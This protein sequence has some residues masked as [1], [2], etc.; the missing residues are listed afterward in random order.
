M[1][2]HLDIFSLQIHHGP[3]PVDVYED[4][5]EPSEGAILN[6]GHSGGD[7]YTTLR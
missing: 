3:V 4:I 7:Y 5:T 1:L 2:D 6:C